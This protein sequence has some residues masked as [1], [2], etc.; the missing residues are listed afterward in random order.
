MTAPRSA[1]LRVRLTPD[2]LAALEAIARRD[3]ATVSEVVR[4]LVAAE[5]RKAAK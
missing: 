4:R 5:I 1:Y 2:Q 3:G